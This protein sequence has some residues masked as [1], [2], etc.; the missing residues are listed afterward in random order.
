MCGRICMSK[1]ADPVCSLFLPVNFL[2]VHF[3]SQHLLTEMTLKEIHLIHNGKKR[4]IQQLK[5]NKIYIYQITLQMHKT[6][7]W[8]LRK[9]NCLMLR[10]ITE[11]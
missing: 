4:H 7:T 1:Y 9:H 10:S 2:P 8:T 6:V 3:N 11:T 5:Q